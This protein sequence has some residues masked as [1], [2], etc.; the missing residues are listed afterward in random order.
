M[1]YALKTSPFTA[2]ERL[3]RPFDRQAHS[4]A[5][6]AQS[7]ITLRV[8][9][10]RFSANSPILK[11]CLSF[12]CFYLFCDFSPLFPKLFF[13]IILSFYRHKPSVLLRV[14]GKH[15]FIFAGFIDGKQQGHRNRSLIAAASFVQLSLNLGCGFRLPSCAV[16][17][18]VFPSVESLNTYFNTLF[19]M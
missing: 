7:A 16:F 3:T 1:I 4:S 17:H 2:S 12:H 15:H 14:K 9:S 19:I 11:S 6:K 13:T 18:G 5:L 8:A 10:E